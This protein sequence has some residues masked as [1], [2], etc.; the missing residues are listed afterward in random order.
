MDRYPAQTICG[1][2][3]SANYSWFHQEQIASRLKLFVDWKERFRENHIGR[4]FFAK[5][6]SIIF[7]LN[8]SLFQLEQ[9]VWK[10][11]YITILYFILYHKV[12]KTIFHN[13]YFYLRFGKKR[14]IETWTKSFSHCFSYN[15][16]IITLFLIN[17]I[18]CD[19]SIKFH[20][21]LISSRT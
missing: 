4:A 13:R 6:C 17:V 18:T 14:T 1:Y 2:I 3:F 8:Y 12:F 21:K 9:I 20:I 10:W 5:I 11:T 7:K 15:K 19:L 16:C